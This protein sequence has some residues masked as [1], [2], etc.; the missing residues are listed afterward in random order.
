MTANSPGATAAALLALT[1]AWPQSAWAEPLADAPVDDTPRRYLMMLP[2]T[3]VAEIA[4]EVLGETLGSSPRSP[5]P[6][7]SG[8]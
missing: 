2:Q 5:A 6:P 1:L 3:P 4:E 7:T 8:V